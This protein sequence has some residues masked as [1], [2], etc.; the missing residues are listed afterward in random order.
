MWQVTTHIGGIL[1]CVRGHP[2]HRCSSA[3]HLWPCTYDND[4]KLPLN[5]NNDNNN[6]N[7]NNNNILIII[8]I[9][10]SIIIIIII[11]IVVIIIIIIII[12][13]LYTGVC[14]RCHS[15][16]RGVRCPNTYVTGGRTQVEFSPV[17]IMYAASC[18][19]TSHLWPVNDTSGIPLYIR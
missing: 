7:N 14:L 13:I 2:L 5:N 17:C 16:V 19:T 1:T 15:Q 9:S 8:I 3:S 12:I 6:N 18:S 11:V 10:S 4:K